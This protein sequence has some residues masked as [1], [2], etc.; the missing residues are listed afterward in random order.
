MIRAGKITAGQKN[1]FENSWHLY[2]LS[3][4]SGKI[5]PAD[6]FGRDAPLVLEIGFGMGD[7]LF[8]MAKQ[9]S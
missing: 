5:N 7:S 2:G 9:V 1:A 6:L 8:Q 3:L 4:F